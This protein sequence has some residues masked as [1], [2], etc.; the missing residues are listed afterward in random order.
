M[1]ISLGW[2]NQQRMEIPD[3]HKWATRMFIP[4]ATMPLF[5]TDTSLILGLLWQ[6]NYGLLSICA[7]HG[8]AAWVSASSGFYRHGWQHRGWEDAEAPRDLDDVIFADVK[9]KETIFSMSLHYF[10]PRMYFV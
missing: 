2:V 6:P 3:K 10:C 5:P 4:V 7:G 8:G 1:K 9:P